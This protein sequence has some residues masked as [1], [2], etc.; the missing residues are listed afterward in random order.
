MLAVDA[1]PDDR[2]RFYFGA[3][4]GGVWRTDR[5]GPHLGADLRCRPGRIDRRPFRGAV[6]TEYDLYRH[7]EADMRSDIAQGVGMFPS[8][9][10]GQNWVP[11]G[12]DDTQQIGRI[13]VDPR[14]ANVCWWRHLGTRTGQTRCAV[15]SA[16]PTGGRTW[17]KTLFRDADTGAIDLAFQT[18]QSGCRLWRAVANTAAAVERI[19]A[20][21]PGRAAGCINLSMAAAAGPI[22]KV[23]AYRRAS[24]ASVSRSPRRGRTGFNALID[25]KQGGAGCSVGGCGRELG[26]GQQ[27]RTHPG[28]R[29]VFFGHH[30]GPEECRHHLRLR[31]HPACAPPMAVGISFR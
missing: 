7:R 5:C 3:V 6:R 26:A 4:N 14:D 12:L 25:A 21:E 24:A 20:I 28:T 23:T 13:L 27:R 30:G 8:T 9:D 11:I 22:S 17:S 19:S 1:S 16:L 10:A 2:R 15:C 29:L 18:R 31:H